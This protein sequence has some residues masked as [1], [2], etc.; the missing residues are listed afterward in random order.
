MA[1]AQSSREALTVT[2]VCSQNPRLIPG[3]LYKMR[4]VA[5]IRCRSRTCW[6]SYS[7]ST[8]GRCQP[9]LSRLLK[10]WKRIPAD[11]CYGLLGW[12]GLGGYWK[13][14]EAENTTSWTGGRQTIIAI[15]NFASIYFGWVKSKQLCTDTSKC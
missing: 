6:G 9:K 11:A 3:S 8:S 14:S 5:L 2:L 10:L 15:P 7:V 13:V 1:L 12:T 4:R